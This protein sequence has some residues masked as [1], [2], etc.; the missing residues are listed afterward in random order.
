MKYATSYE[1]T[2]DSDYIKSF[3]FK[4]SKGTSLIGQVFVEP[5]IGFSIAYYAVPTTLYEDWI[6]KIK[7]TDFDNFYHCC[8]R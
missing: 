8:P 5:L 3:E 7:K 2:R 6:Q 4:I 1:N